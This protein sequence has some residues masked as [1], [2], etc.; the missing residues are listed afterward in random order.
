MANTSEDKHAIILS[1]GGADGAYEVGVLKALFSGMSKSTDNSLIEPSVFSGTS[2]GAFNAAYLTSHWVKRGPAAISDLEDLWLHQLCATPHMSE[3][4]VFRYRLNPLEV[5]DPRSY[6]SNPLR[7]F[8][9]L[10]NDT[11]QLGWD[12]IQR[13]IQL[14]VSREASIGERVAALFNLNSFID[15]SPLARTIKDHIDFD[16][17]RN[18][19]IKLRIAATNWP[20][21][22]LRI[23]QNSDMTN[24]FGPLAILA[25]T[26]IPGI[27]PQTRVG[28]EPFVDGGVLM[29]TPL[30]PAVRAGAN[31]LHVIYLSADVKNIPLA[32]IENT[33]TM[34][35]RSQIIGWAKAYHQDIE[36]IRST[37]KKLGRLKH[38][39]DAGQITEEE[40]NALIKV[41]PTAR[42]EP[43]TF[44]KYRPLTVHRYFPHDPISGVL[45]M[46]D[47]RQASVQERIERGFNDT[48]HY[49]HKA[50][51]SVIPVPYVPAGEE[52]QISE[53]VGK[54][55]KDQEALE[56][57]MINALT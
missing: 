57:E 28:A 24:Q 44:D 17:I 31:I 23:Y 15:R 37:N 19:D 52:A 7:P 55:I 18:S 6:L 10:A 1:G 36:S 46:L 45:G 13:L 48:V 5:L 29:N 11:V 12:G 35:Y 22:T 39:I 27:F 56:R 16:S 33:M 49:D 20:R 34:T 4:G 14:V 42:R 25:S 26:S 43:L 47:F 9:R 3:Y 32:E 2:V 38:L 40:A 8:S 41:V 30:E 50:Q 54:D 51:F 53:D 21:G